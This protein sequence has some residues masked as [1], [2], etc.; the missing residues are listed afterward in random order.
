[1]GSQ[2]SHPQLWHHAKINGFSLE[3]KKKWRSFSGDGYKKQ[4][5]LGKRGLQKMLDTKSEQKWPLVVVKKATK[6]HF[7]FTAHHA[8]KARGGNAGTNQRENRFESGFYRSFCLICTHTQKN[9]AFWQPCTQN[10]TRPI[11]NYTSLCYNCSTKCGGRLSAFIY[12]IL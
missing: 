6:G 10:W 7:L 3:K 5:S 9:R 1:M 2:R 8:Q 11:A 4:G 12:S